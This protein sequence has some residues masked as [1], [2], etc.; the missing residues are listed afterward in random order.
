M[1]FSHL[2]LHK[3]GP[4]MKV[5]LNRPEARHALSLA[6]LRE[7][8]GLAIRLRD[9]PSIRVVILTGGTRMF[10]AGLDLKDPDVRKILSGSAQERRER[11]WLGSAVCDAWQDAPPITIAA[12]EGFC[13]GGG[14]S[15]AISCDWRIMGHSAYMNVPEIDLGL[16]YSW[17]SI[18]RLVRLVGPARAKQIVILAER[19]SAEQCA[20]W[21]L[22]DR[23]VPD[24]AAQDASISLAHTVLQKPPIPV[25][26][27][28]QAVNRVSH[29]HD[30]AVIDMDADQFMLTTY[31]QDHREGLA[32]FL[33][34]RKP[35]FKGE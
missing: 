2:T 32:A 20:L 33:E 35:E 22:A 29:A 26:M 17:G 15:L 13:I 5:T 9:D 1:D 31:T 21:G 30:R 4:I 23:V 7:L 34:K 24:G 12:V 25:A 18:P 19:I 14:V 8:R 28:K 11:V 27:A 6:L 3:D 16:N 10:S